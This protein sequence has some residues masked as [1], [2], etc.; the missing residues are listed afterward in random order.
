MC[1]TLC[2][3]LFDAWK[4]LHGIEHLFSDTSLA[5]FQKSLDAAYKGKCIGNRTITKER[6]NF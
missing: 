3:G 6:K 2:S 1:L 4:Q 5:Y